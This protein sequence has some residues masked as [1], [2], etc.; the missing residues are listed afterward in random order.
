MVVVRAATRSAAGA[1]YHQGGAGA[2]TGHVARAS[3]A[4]QHRPREL[5]QAGGLDET[6]GR[7]HPQSTG[8]VAGAS[9]PFDAAPCWPS[10]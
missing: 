10:T 1:K 8:A 9:H 4:G 7:A 3:A 2:V 6:G 5:R